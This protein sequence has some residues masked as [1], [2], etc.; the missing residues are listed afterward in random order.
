MPAALK[1]RN[2]AI[3]NGK[4]T[5][6]DELAAKKTINPAELITNSVKIQPQV[7]SNFKLDEVV[8]DDPKVE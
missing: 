6:E 8:A 7:P 5:V 1:A 2:M 4:H 3:R